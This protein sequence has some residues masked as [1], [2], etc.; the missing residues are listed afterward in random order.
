MMFL[1]GTVCLILYV[2]YGC[3]AIDKISEKYGDS[4]KSL[5]YTLSAW[6]LPFVAVVEIILRL[7]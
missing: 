3:W 2:A 6:L 7:K 1:L 4:S 5:I